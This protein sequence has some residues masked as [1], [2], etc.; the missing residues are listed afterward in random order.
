[1]KSVHAAL[2]CVL[3]YAQPRRAVLHQRQTSRLPPSGHSRHLD[4]FIRFPTCYTVFFSHF[5]FTL[6]KCPLL[7]THSH[8]CP[9]DKDQDGHFRWVDKT[10]VTFSNYGPG[11][12]KNTANMWDCGQIF[13]GESPV[14]HWV[15]AASRSESTELLSCCRKLWRHVGNDQLLQEPGLHLWDDRRAEPQ[16]HYH[17]WLVRLLQIDAPHLR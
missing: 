16:T 17:A 2:D 13:T 9:P 10:E 5:L 7:L 4:W 12:P 8:W 3:T 1:M 15:Q 14:K 6:G 11:W